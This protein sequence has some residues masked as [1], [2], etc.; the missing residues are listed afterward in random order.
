MTNDDN[1][2]VISITEGE[3]VLALV[4]SFSGDAD[5]SNNT[6]SIDDCVDIATDDAEDSNYFPESTNNNNDSYINNNDIII[7]NIIGST[8]IHKDDEISNNND[9]N[10][11]NYASTSITIINGESSV[12]SAYQAQDKMNSENFINCSDCINNNYNEYDSVVDEKTNA[13]VDTIDVGIH[14]NNKESFDN[15]TY[16]N[17]ID[18]DIHNNNGDTCSDAI[19]VHY[20]DG[21]DDNKIIN[22]C[23]VCCPDDKSNDNNENAPRNIFVSI[24]LEKKIDNLNQGSNQEDL[25][26]SVVI[27]S[28]NTHTSG[29]DNDDVDTYNPNNASDGIN[30]GENDV[31]DDNNYI[32]H[33][34]DSGYN[35]SV[36]SNVY[37]YNNIHDKDN[38]FSYSVNNH[39]N[40]DP[41]DALVYDNNGNNKNSNK[42]GG[43][44]TISNC[45][46]SSNII[47]AI[48]DSDE[49]DDTE[50]NIIILNKD[51]N[52]KDRFSVMANLSKC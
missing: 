36:V 2:D 10:D 35:N 15:D 43:T 14:N 31:D 50:Y 6:D 32:K 16:S 5:S 47:N 29:I 4:H 28:S 51:G 20:D 38:V 33:D 17:A 45:I 13:C 42:N 24:K 39:H 23:H 19:V 12:Q 18:V 11:M 1:V 3:F 46:D 44:N 27:P 37:L 40:N 30:N 49:D 52:N 9:S 22:S 48:S 25:N 7:V 21:N 26:C 41:Y 34:S 8:D